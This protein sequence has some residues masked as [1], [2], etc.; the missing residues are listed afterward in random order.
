M[1][2]MKIRSVPFTQSWWE[3]EMAL[4]TARDRPHGGGPPDRRSGQRGPR[5]FQVDVAA[6]SEKGRNVVERNAAA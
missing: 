1:C 2:K 4:V 6:V 5:Y 3:S